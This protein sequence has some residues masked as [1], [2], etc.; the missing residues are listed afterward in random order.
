[1]EKRKS[2]YNRISEAN[3]LPDG[4]LKEVSY[5]VL[6]LAIVAKNRPLVS[7]NENSNLK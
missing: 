7:K 4:L 5:D 6:A 3:I 1:M 2:L